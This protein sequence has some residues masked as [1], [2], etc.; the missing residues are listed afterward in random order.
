MNRLVLVLL[1]FLS[2]GLS[3]EQSTSV[4]EIRS[5]PRT[6]SPCPRTST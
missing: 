5:R 2:I 4:P 1:P 6:R 3:A